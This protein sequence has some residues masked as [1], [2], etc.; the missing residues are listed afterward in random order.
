MKKE[1][2]DL[3]SNAK[4]T[5]SSY[6]STA[7]F[8][9]LNPLLN[10]LLTQN[11]F[12]PQQYIFTLLTLVSSM[13][14]FSVVSTAVLTAVL[15]WY[16]VIRRYSKNKLIWKTGYFVI[17]GI[18]I[19]IISSGT[20]LSSF[21]AQGM[22]EESNILIFSKA[23]EQEKG[24]LIVANYSSDSVL[25]CAQKL[26]QNVKANQVYLYDLIMGNCYYDGQQ[27][28]DASQCIDALKDF[29]Y[30]VILMSETAGEPNYLFTTVPR[31]FARFDYTADYYAQC[32]IAEAFRHISN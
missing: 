28:S 27:M 19:A 20:V 5:V 23:V 17:V 30:A 3:K 9:F 15:L 16:G 1:L 21:F 4:V 24:V 14:I 13:V 18:V 29:N 6:Y 11:M 25:A 12:T 10:S 22:L 31:P 26:G 32:P 7:A 8:G 2:V